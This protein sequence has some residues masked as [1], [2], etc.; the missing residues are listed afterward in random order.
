M[1]LGTS[2][3]VLIV[4]FII[5]LLTLILL[6]K[7]RIPVKFSILWFLVSFILFL[8]GFFPGFI[9]LISNLMGFQTMS[10]ML[11]GILIFILFLLTIAL[12]VIVSGQ[13]TKIIILI[14]EVSML[15]KKINDMEK[16]NG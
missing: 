15:K 7:G 2:I 8:V 14:Q 1:S 9:S 12:T 10:N 13:T 6:R 16:K 11:V 3:L 4:A 5:F